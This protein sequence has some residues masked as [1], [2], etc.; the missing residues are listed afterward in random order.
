MDAASSG[1]H[2]RSAR[3]ISAG[4]LTTGIVGMGG[5]EETNALDTSTIHKD[6]VSLRFRHLIEIFVV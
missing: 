6:T 4:R 3:N 2:V 1:D 5:K